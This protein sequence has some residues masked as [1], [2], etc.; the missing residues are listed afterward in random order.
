M[1]AFAVLIVS[2][3]NV[4]LA[5]SEGLMSLLGALGHGASHPQERLKSRKFCSSW[6]QEKQ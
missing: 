5:Q 2:S 3:R 1:C 6:L 4:V